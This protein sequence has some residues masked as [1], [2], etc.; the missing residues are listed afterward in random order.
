[1]PPKK[2]QTKETAEPVLAV[3]LRPDT[4]DG[5]IGQEK[6][7]ETVKAQLTSGRI[8]HFF[9]ICGPVGGG[10]TTLGRII[11]NTIA[12]GPHAIDQLKADCDSDEEED[13]SKMGDIIQINASDHNGVD[14]VRELI[15]KM[16]YKPVRG[17]AKVVI[18]DE[19]HQLT[20]QAQN[21]LL[22]EI[23]EPP[24]HA[25]WIFCTSADAKIEASL[26][27]RAFI[28][29]PTPMDSSS[30]EMLLRDAAAHVKSNRLI[31]PLVKAL[32]ETE[33][34][35]PGLVLQAAERYFAGA[36]AEDSVYFRDNTI[37]IN[38]LKFCNCVQGGNW[39]E[40]AA[41]LTTVT[42]GDV[43]LLRASILGYFK[44]AL[45]RNPSINTKMSKV[46]KAME[47]IAKTPV[48]DSL[49]YPMFVS[50]IYQACE[51]MAPKVDKPVT[52]VTPV[53]NKSPPKTED[54]VTPNKRS[55]VKS[56]ESSS[57]QEP[58]L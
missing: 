7:V 18:L 32:E 10:K 1:M 55:R 53:K 41:I 58:K 48:E 28:L 54:S 19:A 42:K 27:R 12:K 30:M 17:Y 47:V 23:E 31:E 22:T 29:K 37:S 46:A 51:I 20:K 9:L 33:I 43:Y 3:G 25:Y 5:L 45:L 2:Q 44:S 13:H 56:S 57:S 26:K 52:T 50:S 6:L 39:K 15:V 24:S 49:C 34:S 8:P 36:E 38:S 16:R 21:A 14:F 35:A 40:A 4:L 11:A